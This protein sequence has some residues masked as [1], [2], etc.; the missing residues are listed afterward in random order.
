[1]I[2]GFTE[3]VKIE[4]V[5]L[6]VKTIEDVEHRKCVVK[7]ARD[8]DEAIAKALGG[9][10]KI[11]EQLRKHEQEKAYISID[12]LNASAVLVS[13]KGDKVTVPAI[14]G[15][16]AVA[17]AGKND[18]PPIIRLEFEFFY[19][20]EAWRFLGDNARGTIELTLKQ[21]QQELL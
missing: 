9:K 18:D 6:D 10:S 1:M 3:T 13:P 5:S 17:V 2:Q 4:S 16:Q 15:T 12:N 14:H 21:R 20:P 8:F 11:L 7:F 19:E